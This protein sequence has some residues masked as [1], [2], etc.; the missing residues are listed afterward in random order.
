VPRVKAAALQE[1][2]RASIGGGKSA[3]ILRRAASIA[4]R[5]TMIREPLAMIVGANLMFGTTRFSHNITTPWNHTQ[6][7]NMTGAFPHR[8]VHGSFLHVI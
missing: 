1:P 4:R 8:R 7:P 5:E 2:I 3:Q 6:T